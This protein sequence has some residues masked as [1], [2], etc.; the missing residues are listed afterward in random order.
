[1]LG[2]V[3]LHPHRDKR[4]SEERLGWVR[5][6]MEVPGHGVSCWMFS[7]QQPS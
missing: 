4:L 2:V 5:W 7:V 1:M 3:F 6:I